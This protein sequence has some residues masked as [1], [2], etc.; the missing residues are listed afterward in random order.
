MADSP[1]NGGSRPITIDKAKSWI[2]VVVLVFGVMAGV[3]AIY[4]ATA[5]LE[6]RLEALN[7]ILVDFK[8]TITNVSQDH[9]KRIRDISDLVTK[10]EVLL[11]RIEDLSSKGSGKEGK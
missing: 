8:T 10:H 6:A 4:T 5:G 9:E 11:Y 2:E 3:H 7:G 1:A